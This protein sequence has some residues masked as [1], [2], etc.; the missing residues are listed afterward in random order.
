MSLKSIRQSNTSFRT[1]ISIMRPDH[2][3]KNIFA[4]PGAILA[5]VLAP[6][7]FTVDELLVRSIIGLFALCIAASANYTINEYLDAEFDRF[8]PYKNLRPGAKG[9]LRKDIV[10]MQYIILISLS[11]TLAY[12]VGTMFLVWTV[13]LLIMGIFYNVRPFRTKDRGIVDVLSESVNNPIRLMMGWHVVQVDSLPPSSILLSYWMGGAFLMAVKRYAE[14]R[15][16]GNPDIAAQYRA[17]FAYYTET[18]LLLSTF[19][20]AI[21]SSFFLG[22]FLIKYRV[23]YILTFP[24]FAVLFV[25]YLWIGSSTDSSAQRPEKIYRERLFVIYVTLLIMLM[26]ILFLVDIPGLAFLL[27]VNKY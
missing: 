4:I 21:T 24:L 5:L 19:F 2:W 17:S 14:F 3:F 1:Y 18:K 9:L 22:I 15:T 16:I 13:V 8:H 20:Y 11:L 27:E 25:W 12:M 6:V 10:I 23:E 7:S 26:V